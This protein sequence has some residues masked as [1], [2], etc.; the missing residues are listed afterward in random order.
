MSSQVGGGNE[1]GRYIG[2]LI[3]PRLIFL[4]ILELLIFEFGSLRI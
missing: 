4:N 2:T 1:F 3:K